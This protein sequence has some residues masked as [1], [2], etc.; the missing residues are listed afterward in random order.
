M[1]NV[2]IKSAKEL[3]ALANTKSD[4]CIINDEFSYLT[5]NCVAKDE[6]E[7]YLHS[8]TIFTYLPHRKYVGSIN[9]QSKNGC[10]GGITK[11]YD[12]KTSYNNAIKRAF[13]KGKKAHKFTIRHW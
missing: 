1:T 10:Y 9:F 5:I 3:I 13:N 12:N 4:T 6:N 8:F 11:F 2:E 7:N